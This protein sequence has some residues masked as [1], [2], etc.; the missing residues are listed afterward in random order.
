MMETYL[1]SLHLN[2]KN[3][4]IK[5]LT[6]LKREQFQV[7]KLVTS[8]DPRHLKAIQSLMHLLINRQLLVTVRMEE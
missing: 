5:S 3:K 7:I 2:P 4:I 6:H 1:L 8:Q